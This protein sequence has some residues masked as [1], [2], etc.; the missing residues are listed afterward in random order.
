[1]Y[2]MYVAT[3]AV[4]TPPDAMAAF[5]AAGLAGTNPLSTAFVASNWH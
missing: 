1:M 4:L 2:F 3:L 5:A